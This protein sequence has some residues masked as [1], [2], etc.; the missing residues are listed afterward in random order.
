MADKSTIEWTD[1]TWN[2]VTGCTKVSPGCDHCYA[3]SITNRF[4]RQP[5]EQVQ[6]HPDRIGQPYEWKKPRRIFVCSMGDLFHT[7]V[8]WDF[9]IDVFE[10]MHQTPEHTYQVLTKRP[11]R[12][13]YFAYEILPYWGM[14]WPAN[15]WAGTSVESQKYAPRLDVLARVPARIRFVS[16][17]PA[18]GPVDF[19]PWLESPHLCLEDCGW[20]NLAREYHSV[21]CATDAKIHWVIAG[22]ESGPGAR[23]AHPEWFRSTRDQC[24]AAGV[25]FFYKQ[26]T[27]DGKKVSLPELDD[28]QWQEIPI[29]AEGILS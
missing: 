4:K 23:P 26:I 27:I 18:L 8:P 5:F 2:P 12:M 25:P 21:E 13:A 16:Y 28:R 24:Q 11:G 10:T 7:Q 17:E 3:E 14:R 19:R 20:D 15:I 6:I 29:A 22:G 9:V 1:A